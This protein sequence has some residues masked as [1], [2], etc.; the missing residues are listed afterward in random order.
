MHNDYSYHLGQAVYL[1]SDHLEILSYGSPLLIQSKESFFSGLSKP[2]NPE[3]VNV[4]MKINKSE[5]SGKGVNTIV[6][7]Y[8][9]DIFELGDYFLIINIPYNKKII[10]N[11]P[12]NEPQNELDKSLE[13]KIVNLIMEDKK[14]TRSE[15]SKN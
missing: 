1:F 12:Q 2:I 11:E 15:M 14:I 5:T 3:L 13:D 9:K 8:G 4:F 6:N 7:K 10:I